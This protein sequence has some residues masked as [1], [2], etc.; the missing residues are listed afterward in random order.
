[1][2]A[3]VPNFDILLS[4]VLREAKR[5][6]DPIA[7]LDAQHRAAWAAVQAGDEYVTQ[8][9]DEG[10]I[11]IANRELPAMTLW[12]LYE[13]ALQV[14]EAQPGQSSGDVRVGDFSRL[15]CHLG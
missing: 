15:P 12:Q 7:Y 1:M 10:G 11:V 9:Q 13:L 3:N 4:G 8:N 5:Q 2:A 6:Q 14:L